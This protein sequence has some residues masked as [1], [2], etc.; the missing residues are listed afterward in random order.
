MRQ[1]IRGSLMYKVLSTR[2]K[3]EKTGETTIGSD[4]ELIKWHRVVTW[5]ELGTAKDMEEARRMFGGR[6]A[7]QWIG[8]IH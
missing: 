8:E 1:V 5:P 4:G 7:L 6:P 3:T 2:P